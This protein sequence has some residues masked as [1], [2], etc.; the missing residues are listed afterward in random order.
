MRGSIS[1]K[2]SSLASTLAPMLRIRDAWV[3]FTDRYLEALDLFALAVPPRPRGPWE[4]DGR[5]QER[6]DR[7]A[8]LV[9]W[10]GLLL[11]RF[12][13]DDDGDRLD[14]LTTHAA[15]GG[16]ELTFLQAQLAHRRGESD[17]AKQ[18]VPVSL[19]RLPGHQGFLDFAIETGAPIPPRAQA[20]LAQRA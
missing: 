1:Q 9:E 20:V 3:T 15:L 18:L 11:D 8:N 7:T 14:R 10:H 12:A 19:E 16:P 2:E 13:D 6:E 17:R 4:F 5:T